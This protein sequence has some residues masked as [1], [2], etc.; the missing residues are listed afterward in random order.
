MARHEEMKHKL[1]EAQCKADR[2][3]AE[4]VHQEGKKKEC[5][6]AKKNMTQS[7]GVRRL[8]RRNGSSRWLRSSSQV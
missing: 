8:P 7:A 6:D 2:E 1:E 4:W 5:K 3:D